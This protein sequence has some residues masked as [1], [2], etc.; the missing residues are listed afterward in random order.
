MTERQQTVLR[1]LIEEYTRTAEPVASVFLARQASLD[2]SSATIRHD[3]AALENAGYIVQP[4]P[5]AGRVPTVKGYDFYL[6]NFLRREALDR[7]STTKL[8]NALKQFGN[9]REALKSLARLIAN[10]SGSAVI[11]A[12]AEN[13]VYYTG[14][15]L[16]FAKKEFED[17]S[18]LLNLSRMLDEIDAAAYRELA[19]VREVEILLGDKCPFDENCAVIVGHYRLGRHRGF[20]GIVGPMRMDYNLNLNLINFMNNL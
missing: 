11:V 7:D 17:K 19:N 20:V 4:H 6:K 10:I 15:S 16:L 2:I 13:D 1:S 12:L 14:L 9:E 8:E 18:L 5:S 3:L